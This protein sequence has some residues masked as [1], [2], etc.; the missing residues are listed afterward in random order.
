MWMDEEEI[1]EAMYRK[2]VE[3]D[4]KDFWVLITDAKWAYFYCKNV[5]DRASVRKY[6]TESQWAYYYCEDI[7]NRAEIR[8]N[9]TDSSWNDLYYEKFVFGSSSKR[10]ELCG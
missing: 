10:I 2:C 3:N 8:K 9:I 4:K 7:E 1:S 6:I 5:K